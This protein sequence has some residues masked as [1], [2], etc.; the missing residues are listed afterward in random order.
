MVT[1]RIIEIKMGMVGRKLLKKAHTPTVLATRAIVPSIKKTFLSS[2][3]MGDNT[4]K[5]G[6]EKTIYIFS[7]I[8]YPARTFVRTV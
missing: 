2:V 6:K 7:R 1:N 3:F 8:V 4:G 5:R